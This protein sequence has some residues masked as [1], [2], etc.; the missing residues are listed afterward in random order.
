MIHRGRSDRLSHFV[1]ARTI[2]LLGLYS[3]VCGEDGTLRPLVGGG[4]YQQPS[5]QW[6]ALRI[7]RGEYGRLRA[8]DL[9]KQ[10]RKSRVGRGR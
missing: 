8:A 2:R 3:D 9:E 6:A 4:V 10:E 5:W 1:S 7:A